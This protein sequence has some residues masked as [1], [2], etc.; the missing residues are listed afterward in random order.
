MKIN[1]I[2][3]LA[4]LIVFNYFNII[5]QDIID[6]PKLIQLE[7]ESIV[8]KE[9]DRFVRGWTCGFP[10]NMLDSAMFINT[11]YS[12]HHDY[13]QGTNNSTHNLLIIN[14]PGHYESYLVAGRDENVA[15]NTQSLYL[16]PSLEVDTTQNFVPRE[17][18]N[19][20]AAMGF[21]KG[22]WESGVRN[23]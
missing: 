22:N 8:Q 19:T 9:P 16:E 4:I 3:V 7:T 5:S 15:F 20:G 14:R 12:Y 13:Y 10:G 17:N 18:D 1:I 11:Y 6:P 23:L 21:L 2:L